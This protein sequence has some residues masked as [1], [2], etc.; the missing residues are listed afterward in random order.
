[1]GKNSLALAATFLLA[2][3]SVAYPNP[4]EKIRGLHGHDDWFHRL[5]LL[6]RQST[7]QALFYM[8]GVSPE[9]LA[10]RKGLGSALLYRTLKLCLD[11]GYQSIL[12]TLL[13]EDSPARYFAMDQVEIAER[14]YA[15]FELRYSP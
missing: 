13:S 14:E 2:G 15:L 3:F 7:D 8:I 5:K 11:A 12:F 1:M 4:S 9:L 10:K 6:R